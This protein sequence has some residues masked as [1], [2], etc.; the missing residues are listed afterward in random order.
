MNIKIVFLLLIS[1]WSVMSD[2]NSSV[3][4]SDV[5]QN[6]TNGECVEGYGMN[7]NTTGQDNNVTTEPTTIP[8]NPTS[9]K[10]QLDTILTTIGTIIVA[11]T[12]LLVIIQ[13]KRKDKLEDLLAIETV[14][15]DILTQWVGPFGEEELSGWRKK[16]I[17]E[18]QTPSGPDDPLPMPLVK[19]EKYR[20][21]H[22][23]GSKET[24]DGMI[25]CEYDIPLDDRW[26]FP[27]QSLSL[28]KTLGEGAFGKVIRAE[29]EG[30]IQSGIM[31]TVAVK[32]LKEGHTDGDMINLV[33]E[34]EVIK[35]IGSHINIINLL[36]I[37]TQEGPLYIIVE[38][39]EHNNLRDFLRKHEPKE[40]TYVNEF[41]IT[42]R[43]LISFAYQIT[44]G[45]KYLHSK[46][47]I[48]RDLAARNVLVSKNYTMKIADF[49]LARDVN[50]QDYYRQRTDGAVPVRWVAPEA[51][52]HRFYTYQSDV[53]SFGIL[54]WEIMTFGGS[55]YPSV[56]NVEKLFQ[57]LRNGHRMECPSNCPEEVYEIMQA[58]WKSDPTERPQ[59][60]DLVSK[61]DNMLERKTMI[62]NKH[63]I[64]QQ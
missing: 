18:P 41:V 51:L 23:N 42:Q 8:T 3:S 16:I 5:T 29:A 6:V 17:I 59:F 13:Q 33:S 43:D 39:A 30:I 44:N 35:M 28:G 48:H 25:M 36:G 9:D 1:V 47:C 64:N 26:E 31:T 55:P 24:S 58:C 62:E 21:K 10:P 2:T 32:M 4:S 54:L 63:Y 40:N 19:L 52:F 50:N 60:S 57:L 49:G 14:R 11:V 7:C 53:W 56:P 34:M 45:M 46:R 15:E 61:L 22:S 37:C 12:I 20:S 38:Y 27:R